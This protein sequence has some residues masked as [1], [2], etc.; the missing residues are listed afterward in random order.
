MARVKIGTFKFG[1]E[2][3]ELRYVV[4][5]KDKQVLFVGKDIAT[6]LKYNDCKQAIRTN[7]DE[8]YKTTMK[9]LNIKN[10]RKN[11]TG[12][13][14]LHTI[15]INKM[16]IIQLIMKSHMS[17]AEEFQAW[18]FE[19]VLPECTSNGLELMRDAESNITFSTQLIEGYIYVATNPIYAEKN[20]YKIGQT[21]NLNTRL[22]SLNC[23][24][25]DFDLM[26]YV[27]YTQPVT[28]YVL[29][30][31]LIKY[32]LGPYQNHGEVY[33]VDVE[34]IQDTIVKCFNMINKEQL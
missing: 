4:N 7:V 3:F 31:K 14:Q 13:L 20:L 8:K 6:V 17:N 11:E 19:H 30:E 2:E 10:A 9:A 1:K 12:H 18:F 27:I 29:L 24:R 28:N 21:T 25:A 22:A 16:G 32:E 26:Q 23:G 5:D 33:Q 34:H 15:L